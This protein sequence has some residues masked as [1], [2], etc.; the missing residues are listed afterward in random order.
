MPTTG[1]SAVTIAILIQLQ[2]PNE[3]V[4]PAVA[5][6]EKLSWLILLSR[7]QRVTIARQPSMSIL[8]PKKPNSSAHNANIKSVLCSGKN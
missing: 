1:I 3:K 6:L 7:K 2:R 4:I 8:Q 5:S